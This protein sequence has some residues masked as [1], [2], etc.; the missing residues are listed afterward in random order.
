M[1]KQKLF[2]TVFIGIL[3]FATSVFAQGGPLTKEQDKIVREIV[4]EGNSYVIQKI[5]AIDLDND[6]NNEA[7]VIYFFGAHSSG[8]KVIKFENGKGA[9]I[10]EHETGTPVTEF[11]LMDNLPTL[12]FEASDLTPNYASAKRSEDI[13]QWSGKTFEL[14]RIHRGE[15]KP[16]E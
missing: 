11:E 12:I 9:V 4:K 1:N 5:I 13:Y 7:V 2:I 10:F 6:K 3:L 15:T 16:N 14:N 8:A